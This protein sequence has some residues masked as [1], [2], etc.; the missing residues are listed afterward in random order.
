[1]LLI[2]QTAETQSMKYEINNLLLIAFSVDNTIKCR[3]M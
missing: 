2:L 1:M 3:K